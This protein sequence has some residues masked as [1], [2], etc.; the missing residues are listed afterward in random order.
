MEIALSDLTGE[1]FVEESPP[2]RVRRWIHDPEPTPVGIP[3][4]RASV[5]EY[6]LKALL[7]WMARSRPAGDP[8]VA[9][10]ESEPTK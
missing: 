1:Q 6:T 8:R 7:G 9:Q 10:H 4:A 3:L 2:L 5:R